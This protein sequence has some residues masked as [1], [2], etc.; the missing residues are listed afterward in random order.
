MESFTYR[1]YDAGGTIHQGELTALDLAS[2][3]FKLKEQGLIPISIRK[4][5]RA[6][7]GLKRLFN[8]DRRP[9]L[10]DLEFATAKLS[11]LLKNGVKIDRALGLV[12]KGIRNR[13]FGK[14]M[15]GVHE[16]VRKGT[17]LS[18]ALE[19]HPDLFGPLYVSIVK[20]GEATGN[21]SGAFADISG[22]L[23]F[24]RD[25]R[26]KT[27][28]ALV[29]PSVILVTCLGAV[30]FIFNFIVPKFSTIFM[31]ADQLPVYTALLLGV[32][33]F[34]RQYQILLGVGLLGV[35]L[36][37]LR[38]RRNAWLKNALDAAVL[39]IPVLKPIAATNEALRFTSALAVLLR[40]GVVL[41]DALD[42]AVR[43]VGNRFLQKRLALVR[44][45]VRKG[46][47]LS[48][49]LDKTGFMP[50]DFEG[51]VAVGEQAGNLSEI[52]SE[53]EARLRTIYEGKIRNMLTLIEPILILV[54]GLV[55]GSVVVVM[56]LS[57]VSINDISF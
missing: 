45:D 9:G 39:K 10:A 27:R 49:S 2:A 28:Q 34:F 36:A 11:L 37:M 7:E 3:R 4:P 35:L 20:I 19:K 32:S 23:A 53:M 26:A 50:D 13:R 55:V 54:M 25:I 51:L 41:S 48:E 47:P 18:K 5:D 30:L 24:T 1:A 16:D 14:V 56:L 15:D 40:S 38:F 21:L 33:D 12:T 22:N 6:A 57:M 43:A 31:D 17:V 8:V 46:T 44:N 29:Y 52:F 42:Y